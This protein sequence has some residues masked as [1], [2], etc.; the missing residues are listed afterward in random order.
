MVHSHRCDS[1]TTHPSRR[2]R[3]CSLQLWGAEEADAAAGLPAAFPCHPR[4]NATETTASCSSCAPSLLI[5]SPRS[6][7]RHLPGSRTAAAHHNALNCLQS[8]KQ[9][10]ARGSSSCQTVCRA[11][12]TPH[13]RRER[14]PNS[15]VTSREHTH[16]LLLGIWEHRLPDCLPML[17]VISA[18]RCHTPPS[19]S[20]SPR[21]Q[22]HQKVISSSHL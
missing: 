2:L 12:L 21:S 17:G 3:A 6:H 7:F 4:T 9:R 18:R 13:G 11:A 20:P 1:R 16:H 19:P 15:C 10:T 14:F 22:H 5:I 8:D